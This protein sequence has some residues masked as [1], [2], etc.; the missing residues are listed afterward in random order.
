MKNKYSSFDEIDRQLQILKLKRKIDM[1]YVK[2]NAQS[3]K[4]TFHRPNLA[5]KAEIVI[6]RLAL[7]FVLK[8]LVTW[9]SKQ[10]RKKLELQ[11]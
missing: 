9:R 7:T 2:L 1:E 4:K 5:Q 3:I 10:K 11:A 6:Q 8:K